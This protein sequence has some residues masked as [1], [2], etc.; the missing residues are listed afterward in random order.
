MKSI[1]IKKWIEPYKLLESIKEDFEYSD[2]TF[3]GS[4]K[5]SMKKEFLKELESN[6]SSIGLY[7]KNVNK[8]YLFTHKAISA[9][10]LWEKLCKEFEFTTADYEETENLEESFHL[11]DIGKSEAN[12]INITIDTKEAKNPEIIWIEG[13]GAGYCITEKYY[14]NRQKENH[15]K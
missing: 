6:T 14:E 11:V 15:K 12:L 5:E 10:Q 2:Y 1:T 3:D 7:M 9:E 13:E 8:Y 4:N